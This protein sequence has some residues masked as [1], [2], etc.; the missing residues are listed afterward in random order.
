M[1]SH[2]FSSYRS[3]FGGLSR[4]TWQLSF[5]MLV[6]RSGTMVVPFMTMY[7]TGSLGASISSAGFVMALFGLGAVAGALTGGKL[8][9]KYGFYP[10]QLWALIG[11]GILFIIL[12]QMH[13]YPLICVFTFLLSFVNE[14]FRPANQTAIAWFSKTENRTRSFTLNRLAINLGWAVG[15]AMGGFLAARNYE[16][17]FW[18]DGCTNLAAALFLFLLIP[19]TK[20]KPENPEQHKEAKASARSAYADKHYLGFILF[21]VI[22]AICFFQLFSTMPIFYKKE[23]KLTETDFGYV[24]ALNGLLIAFIEMPFVKFAEGRIK[25]LTL[26]ITGVLITG[27]SYIVLNIFPPS[28]AAA[29]ISVLLFTFGEILA[30]PFMNTFWTSRSVPA[31]RGEY[32]ALFTIA[33]SIAHVTG[34]Y[35]GSLLAQNQ[36]FDVLWWVTGFVCAIAATGFWYIKKKTNG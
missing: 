21:L 8:T 26:I 36:G 4:Q 6:N 14:S 18:V 10:V 20:T 27:L 19:V 17:L 30:M 16:L 32:A 28:V 25:P 29:F 12:G 1:F 34:P 35:S 33:F 2:L 24:M 9:D 11:G 31:N 5:V 22:F 23:W 7:L 15:S 3:A 13:S